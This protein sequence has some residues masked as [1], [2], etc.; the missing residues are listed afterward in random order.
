LT[1]ATGDARKAA[2]LDALKLAT[3]V[4]PGVGAGVLG[5]ADEQQ[6][7]SAEQH[8]GAD[9]LLLAVVDRPQVDDLLDVAPGALDMPQLLVAEGDLRG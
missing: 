2:E 4:R 7:Q 8:A 3:Q 1:E 5:D 9:A 6:G